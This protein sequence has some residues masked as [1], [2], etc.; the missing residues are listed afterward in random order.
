MARI[1]SIEFEFQHQQYLALVSYCTGADG[2]TRYTVI[3][4]DDNLKRLLPEGRLSF[5]N[6]SELMG[7]EKCSRLHELGVSLAYALHQKLHSEKVYNSR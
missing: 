2:N 6:I 3:P 5:S 4:G 7:L 1:F